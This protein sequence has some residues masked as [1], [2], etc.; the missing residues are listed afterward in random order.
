LIRPEKRA[1]PSSRRDKPLDSSA[2]KEYK[3][4]RSQ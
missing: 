1:A 2:Q 3:I 4:N